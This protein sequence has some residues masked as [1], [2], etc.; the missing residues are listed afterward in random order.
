MLPAK[1]PSGIPVIDETWGGLYRGGAYLLYGRAQSG[2]RLLALQLAQAAVDADETCLFISPS[3]PEALIARASRLGLKVDYDDNRL[4][5]LH[6][7]PMAGDPSD[8]ALE[9]SLSDLASLIRE[10]APSRLIIDDF[11]PFARFLSFERFANAFF[12]LLDRLTGATLILAMH[13]PPDQ[14]AEHLA[15]FVQAQMT[16][17][18]EL[19]HTAPAEAGACTLVLRPGRFH[20]EGAR[21]RNWA[22]GEHLSPSRS[23]TPAASPRRDSAAG[24]PPERLAVPFNPLVP[25]LLPGTHAARV[26][27]TAGTIGDDPESLDPDETPGIHFF[28]FDDSAEALPDEPPAPPF[29]DLPEPPD[30]FMPP[31]FPPGVDPFVYALMDAPP[32]PEPLLFSALPTFLSEPPGLELGESAPRRQFVQAF[33]AALVLYETAA[34]P[35]LTLALRMA[36]GSPAAPDFPLIIRGMRAALGDAY[37]LL[38]DAD[39]LRLV[40]LLPGHTS[41]TGTTVFRD[42]KQFLYDVTPDANLTFEETTAILLANGRPFHTVGAFLT[43]TFDT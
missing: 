39:R 27:A 38:A 18:I 24:V 37:V 3:P 25:T 35:F 8:D 22:F 9:Q 17:V 40:A 43:H 31:G 29:G 34:H 30:E 14:T 41:E 1:A 28:D 23:A 33:E 21:V 13:A 10:Y 32:P 4:R 36:P 20:S 5:L 2:N 6:V 26:L 16:G 11:A 15:E 7:A 42:L 19:D 12:T